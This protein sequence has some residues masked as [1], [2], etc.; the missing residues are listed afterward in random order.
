M[1]LACARRRRRRSRRRRPGSARQSKELGDRVPGRASRRIVDASLGAPVIGFGS[2]RAG[3]AHAGRSSST[4]TTTRPSPHGRNPLFGKAHDFAEYFLAH[5]YRP[6]ELWGSATRAT[7]ATCRPTRRSARRSRTPRPRRARPARLRPR[8]ARLH[9]RRAGRR[10]RAQP[11]RHVTRE[12]PRRTSHTDSSRYARHVASPHHGIINCSPSPVNYWQLPAFGGFTP[13]S[14]VC[15]E[16][17]RRSNT[18]FHERPQRG[19]RDAEA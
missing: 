3:R 13:A 7:S 18:P 12:W 5:G 2:A 6:S 4:A 14:S 9:R 16:A 15:V 10:R 19:R 17:R 1:L 8:R 11:R